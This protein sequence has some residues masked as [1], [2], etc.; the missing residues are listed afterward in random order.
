MKR[1][2][3][4]PVLALTLA[5]APASAL[6]GTH[7]GHATAPIK[8][9]RGGQAVAPAP[10]RKALMGIALRLALRD[11]SRMAYSQSGSRGYLPIGQVP[12]ATDCSG[13]ATWALRNA[14]IDVPLSTSYT[15]M[16][17]GRSVP[18]DPRSM[19]IGDIVVYSG[20]VAVYLGGGLTVGHGSPGAHLSPY[21]YRPVLSVRRF[22]S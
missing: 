7:G 1:L 14:G 11:S 13:F 8:W 21:N 10:D 5:I 6:A 18:A 9:Q 4:I 15:F 22:Y 16:G 2:S 19:Q 3:L 17:E 12:P 20:H